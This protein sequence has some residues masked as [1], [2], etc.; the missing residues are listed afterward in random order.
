MHTG[1]SST[2]N[3][4]RYTCKLKYLAHVS[5]H[6]TNA[7]DKT[8]GRLS[9]HTPRR[10]T[11]ESGCHDN[12]Y[13]H[14]VDTDALS[15]LHMQS[16]TIASWLSTTF[17]GERRRHKK[18]GQQSQ[19]QIVGAAGSSPRLEVGGTGVACVPVHQTVISE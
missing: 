5:L 17:I 15:V 4:S 19:T 2:P 11:V 3:G 8:K 14:Q 1:V 10:K 18:K 12:T 6:T 7:T 16:S 13:S 9:H